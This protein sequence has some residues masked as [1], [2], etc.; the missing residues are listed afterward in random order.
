MESKD[1]DVSI[2]PVC[3]WVRGGN[4]LQ[5]AKYGSIVSAKVDGTIKTVRKRGMTFRLG[6]KEVF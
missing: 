3:V 2:K 5:C 6:R 1:V 4:C